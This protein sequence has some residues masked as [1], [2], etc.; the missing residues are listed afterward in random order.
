MAMETTSP[1]TRSFES[2]MAIH[3]SSP[4]YIH[5][6]IHQAPSMKRIVA[7]SR[8]QKGLYLLNTS[9]I[10]PRTFPYSSVSNAIDYFVSHPNCNQFNID[11]I[12]SFVLVF[13]KISSHD[14]RL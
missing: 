7:L 12:S 13:L 3:S 4:Y 14:V 9:P 11:K 5:F 6:R 8:V 1:N 10:K 2:A